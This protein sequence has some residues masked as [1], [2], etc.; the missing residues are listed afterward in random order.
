MSQGS[1]LRYQ[2]LAVE[3]QPQ[4]TRETFMGGKHQNLLKEG[5]SATMIAIEEGELHDDH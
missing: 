1:D 4:Q 5:L 3:N 2:A